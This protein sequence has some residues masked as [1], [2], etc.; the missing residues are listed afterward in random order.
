MF[1]AITI[2]CLAS[3]LLAACGDRSAPNTATPVTNAPLNHAHEDNHPAANEPSEHGSEK[4][5]EFRWDHLTAP[6]PDHPLVDLKNAKD[7]VSLAPVGAVTLDYKGYTVHFES[8]ATRAKFERKPIKFLNMLSLE[9]HVDGSVTLVDAS[10][11]QDAVTDFCPFMPESE[12][13]PHG[14]VYLLHR[15]WKFFFCCW[16]GCGDKFMQNPAAAYD[17]YGLVERD[18]KL[19]KR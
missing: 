6:T 2:L 5:D 14:S 3:A 13:D 19:V 16:T 12:V 11:Y 18:G 4:E 15:G 8:D 7:P 17:W 9:P 1:R 10:S